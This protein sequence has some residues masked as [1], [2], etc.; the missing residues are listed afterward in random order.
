MEY[1]VNDDRIC[2]LIP[3]RQ[4]VHV[5]LPQACGDARRLELYASKT[6]HLRRPI[7]A[8][9]L[10]GARTEKLD[11]APGAGADIHQHAKRL[12]AQRGPDRPLNLDL[13][14]VE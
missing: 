8:D 12:L 1:L 4:C 11:H 10:A 9:R 13:S 2:A 3:Q 14:D 6:E 5:P 7:N